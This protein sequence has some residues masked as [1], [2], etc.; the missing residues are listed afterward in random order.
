MV[1]ILIHSFI[2]RVDKRS[3]FSS[4]WTTSINSRLVWLWLYVCA[5]GRANNDPNNDFWMFPCPCP[6]MN[7]C[8]VI[9]SGIDREMYLHFGRRMISVVFHYWVVECLR[10]VQFA[11]I[12]IAHIDIY[13]HPRAFHWCKWVLFTL[14][15]IRVYVYLLS[16]MT[17]VA[18][19]P[20]AGVWGYSRWH[21]R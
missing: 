10:S 6:R 3:V 18:H 14:I 12:H 2:W 16:V 20:G 13:A 21:Q 11:S 5:L 8:V 19:S 1:K 4:S 15:H 9:A 7:V 17:A